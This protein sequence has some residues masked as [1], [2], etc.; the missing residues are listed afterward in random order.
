MS[1]ARFGVDSD[2][3]VFLASDHVLECGGCALAGKGGR[4]VFKSTAEI[5]VHLQQH[6]EAGGRVPDSCIETLRADEKDN[7]ALLAQGQP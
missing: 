5:V 6:R 4:T 7:A 3:Y 2:V 1:Y